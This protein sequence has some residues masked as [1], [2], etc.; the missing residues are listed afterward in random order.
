MKRKKL[1]LLDAHAILHRA[2]HAL[3]NFT[4]PKGEPTGALYGFTAFLL[5][6]IRE[7]EPDYIAACYDLPEPTFRK[8]AYEQYKGKRPKMDDSLAE[9]IKRSRDILAVFK[10]P[11]YDSPGFEADDVLGTIVERL[12]PVSSPKTEAPKNLKV[13]IASGDLDTLQLVDDDNVVVYT[14]SKGIKDAVI[15]DEDKVKERYGF[16]PKLLPDFK[17]LKG[18]PSDNIIGVP[19]I[20]DKTGGELIQKFGTIENIY[21]TLRKNPNAFEEAGVKPRTIKLLR[22]NEEEAM[23][24]KGLAEIRRDAPVKFSLADCEWKKRFDIEKAKELFGELGFRSLV[25]RMENGAGG[26]PSART[27]KSEQPDASDGGSA[28]KNETKEL[29]ERFKGTVPEKLFKEVELPLSKILAEMRDRGILLDIPYLAKLSKEYHKELARLEKKIWSLA[30]KEFN[31]NSSKQLGAVLFDDLKL[32]T[33][34]LRKTSGGARSTNIAVLEKLKGL[35]PI[36]EEIV[37]YRELS[38]LVSTYVDALPKLVDKNGRLHT[39]FDQAGTA[40]GRIS[41]KNPNLQNIPKRTE[42]GRKIRKAFVADEGF[43]LVAFDYS[44]IE[45]RIAAILSGDEKMKKVFA[46]DGDIHTAV[47]CEVFGVK[48]DGVTAEMRRRAKIINFG[49]IYGMGINALRANLGCSREEARAFYDEYF[50]GFKGMADYIE[51]V[52]RFARENGYTE[53]LFGRKRFFPEINSPIDYIRKEAERMA[54]NAPIQGTAADFIKLAMVRAD[55][56]L[57]EGGLKDKVFMLL[58]IHDELVFEI[59]DSAVGEATRIIVKA[60]EGVYEGDVPIKTNVFAGKNWEDMVEY[61]K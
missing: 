53:T 57:K 16:E 32:N 55:R 23:F 44:Q 59:N 42:L 5:K 13:I 38:K 37:S 45:L 35:H 48:P 34:G 30:G 24:S 9:Q 1:V 50:K 56:A 14:L 33:K 10:I 31:I 26:A 21:E 49:I 58:Q 15:Y 29:L 20:G 40:T 60:M 8:I 41:S 6:V 25:G 17:G 7:L 19:G 18:D 27:E 28:E 52:K 36:I 39:T 22:E 4:S 2:F 46:E 12:F 61:E 47:A 51:R 54:V 43:K 11:I 3:P